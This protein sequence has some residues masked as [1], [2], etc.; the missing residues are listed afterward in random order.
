ML[1]NLEHT[2]SRGTI[3]ALGERSLSCPEEQFK[4]FFLGNNHVLKEKKLF[5]H[6]EHGCSSE[7]LK[8]CSLKNM[9]VIMHVCMASYMMATYGHANR[10]F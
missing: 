1:K 8:L 4:L 2:F 9:V 3:M 6:Q 10:A 5:F 7:Q